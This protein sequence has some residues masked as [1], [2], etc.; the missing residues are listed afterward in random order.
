MK[1]HIHFITSLATAALLATTAALSAQQTIYDGF[2]TG[3]EPGQYPAGEDASVAVG[4]GTNWSQPSWT[5]TAERKMLGDPV[6]LTYGAGANE[7]AVMEGAVYS[8]NSDGNAELERDFQPFGSGAEVWFSLLMDRTPAAHGYE[9][10]FAFQLRSQTGGLKYSIRALDGSKN[11]HASYVPQGTNNEEIATL[12]NTVYDEPI[13]V[14]GKIS[15]IGSQAATFSVWVNPKDLKELGDPTW[16]SPEFHAQGIGR[17]VLVADGT[18]E[19]KFDE[20]RIGTSKAE[21][22]PLKSAAE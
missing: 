19:G 2:A 15:R 9:D 10:R 18:R 11:W 5:N 6:G 1:T 8:S 16:I 3:T 12:P 4:G 14:V 7:L 20:I 17:A 13:F 21:V 22:V